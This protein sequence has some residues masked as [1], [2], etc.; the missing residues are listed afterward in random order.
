MGLNGTM[1]SPATRTYNARRGRM[2]SGRVDATVRLLPRFGLPGGPLDREVVFGRHAPVVLE[3]GS[4]MGEATVAMASAD[5]GRDYIAVEVYTAGLANLLRLVDAAGLANIRTHH[6]DAMALLRDRIEPA[7]LDAI[8]VFFPDP[9]PKMRHRK[10][11]LIETVW[12]S[13]IVDRIRP[14]GVLHCATDD[15][16]YAADMLALLGATPVLANLHSG[17][18]PRPAYRPETRYERRGRR[19]GRRSYD[20]IFRRL[21]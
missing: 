4:G 10:R 12:V 11:R 15:A 20:L 21:H 3:I 17:F 2:G 18:A 6:G 1:T 8:H 9:W 13:L 16:G 14:G 7:S 5:P 19:A